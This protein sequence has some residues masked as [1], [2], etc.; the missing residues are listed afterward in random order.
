MMSFKIIRGKFRGAK[1]LLKLII[2]I[3]IALTNYHIKNHRL[4]KES[5]KGSLMGVRS[6]ENAIT[7]PRPAEPRQ[8]FCY[9]KP[10]QRL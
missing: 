4:R 8:T 3:T 6:D 9:G 7:V 1:L 5:I 2:P 10:F